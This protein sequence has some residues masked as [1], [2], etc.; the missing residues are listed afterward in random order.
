[1][2]ITVT[3]RHVDTSEAIKQHATDKI[4][5]LQ[6]FLRQPMTAHVTF[7]LEKLLHQVEARISCGGDRFE[8][9]EVTDDMYASIDK[10]LTKLERQIR[11]TKGAAQSKKRRGGATLRGAAGPEVVDARRRGRVGSPVKKK[12]VAKVVGTSAKKRKTGGGK[13]A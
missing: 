9:H 12:T 4:A 3:F 8:A 5:K 10:V 2:N 7:S 6:K 11:G 13:S 1:M